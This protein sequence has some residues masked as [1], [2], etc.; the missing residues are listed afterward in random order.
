MATA[1]EIQER[2]SGGASRR[3]LFIKSMGRIA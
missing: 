2:I 3:H 1:I